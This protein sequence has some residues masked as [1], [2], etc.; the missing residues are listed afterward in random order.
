MYTPREVR[1]DTCISLRRGN[2]FYGWIGVDGEWYERDQV[3]GIEWD[4]GK[5][6]M[7]KMIGIGGNL[8]VVWKHNAMEIF[9]CLQM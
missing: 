8:A 6:M 7:G 2:R 3:C 4:G 1:R 9:W 5:W